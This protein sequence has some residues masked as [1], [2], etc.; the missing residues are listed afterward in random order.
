MAQNVK[1]A[2]EDVKATAIGSVNSRRLHL[3][4]RF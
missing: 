1:G 2:E 4:T 3:P